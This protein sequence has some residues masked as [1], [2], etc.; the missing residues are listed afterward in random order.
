MKVRDSYT[1]RLRGKPGERMICK[2]K[3]SLRSI[4]QFGLNSN[5]SIILKVRSDRENIG[6]SEKGR[7]SEV[8]I[9]LNEPLFQKGSTLFARKCENK[10]GV[11][12]QAPFKIGIF[13][14]SKSNFL[15]T[16]YG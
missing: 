16:D 6:C 3:T 13:N 15:F 14:Y 11:N 9:L 1:V 2:F 12:R 8:L 5:G 10:R 4:A 7:N